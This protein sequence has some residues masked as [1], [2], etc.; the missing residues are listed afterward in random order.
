MIAADVLEVVVEMLVANE[1]ERRRLDRRATA[2]IAVSSFEMV[3]MS[4]RCEQTGTLPSC[5]AS[6]T[7]L[8]LAEPVRPS[9][10]AMNWPTE[11]DG[12]GVLILAN[13]GGD[14]RPEAVRRVPVGRRRVRRPP[15]PPARVGGRGGDDALA[16]PVDRPASGAG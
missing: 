11:R 16:E 2:R 3:G 8:R 10:V 6:S 9:K 14:Q 5:V 1:P 13:A 12:A 7:L 15:L 4:S